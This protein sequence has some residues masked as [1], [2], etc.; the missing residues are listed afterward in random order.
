[1]RIN[2]AEHLSNQD[3]IKIGSLVKLKSSAKTWFEPQLY[4]EWVTSRTPNCIGPFPMDGIGIV[5]EI[6]HG[7][8]NLYSAAVGIRVAVEGMVGWIDDI[9]IEVIK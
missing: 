7:K 8:R 3:N 1:M 2:V 9:K 5:I 4:N 6:S